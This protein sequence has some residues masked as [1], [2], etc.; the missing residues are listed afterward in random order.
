M[1]AT[2]ARHTHGLEITALIFFAVGLLLLLALVTYSSADPSFSVSGAA[3]SVKNAI[4]VIGSYLSDALLKL[5]GLC[6]YL[7]PFFFFAYAA[8]F[9]LGGEAVHPHLKKVGGILLFISLASLLGIQGDTVRLFSEDIPSGGMLGKLFV[10]LLVNSVS[11]TGAYI[12]AVTSLVIS[13]IML[14]PFSLVAVIDGLRRAFYG[15]L[16]R[17]ALLNDI[18]KGRAEKARAARAQ[19]SQQKEPPKI[20]GDPSA[21]SAPLPRLALRERNRQDKKDKSAKPV[22]A[23]FGFME[24]S[25]GG[26]KLPG[27]DLLDPLP[28]RIKKVSEKEMIAQSELLARKL[29][30]FDIQGRVSQVHPGPV[31]TMFEYEPAPGVKVRRIEG[32]ADDLALAMKAASV[33]IV[34]PLPGKAAVGIEV[35][36]NSRETVYF[37]EII[38]SP[39]YQGHR[40]KLRIPLGKDIFGMP[41]IAYVEKMP[42][43]LVA[44]ATGSGKSVAINSIILALLFNARPNEIRLV[45]VDPKMLELSLYN[46]IP[47]LL[48]PV[49]TQP[50]K[51]AETLRAVVAEMERRYR[52]LA[53]KGSKNIDSYNKSV[54]EKERLPYIVVIIDELADLMMTVQKEIEDSIMRLAQMARAAGIHL[55]V[56]TQRPS[57]DVVT[58]LIK[59]NLPSRIA[60]QVSSKTDSRTILDANGAESLLGKGDMLFL[61]PGSPH[62]VRIHGC[63]VSEEEIKRVVEFV[64]KQGKPNY[65]LLQQRVKEIAEAQTASVEEG[66]RDEEYER[67]VDLVQMNGQA[68]TSFLQRRLR[69]GYNRAARM[70]EMME[71]DGIVGPPDGS[72]PRKVLVRKNMDGTVHGLDA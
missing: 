47:H 54:M 65:E 53:E 36:N 39:E 29:L 51:A 5:F 2:K 59:A 9:A 63:F 61:P 69:V 6:A 20:A 68:S 13:L 42:H 28:P 19:P 64:K 25:V 62:L 37:R 41:T 45:M 8:Y 49:V 16:D 12:I 57:V 38:E 18:R 31:V 46:D 17:L 26:Y 10:V 56:A 27:A 50:K 72:K 1:S 7:I 15:A 21:P 60:F 35:P 40:S 52:Q 66:E 67:A 44:G 71:K 14:T 58:G 55:I 48:T 3:G 33:R 11:V 34:S 23:A 22:Q 32:L 43:L 30:D 4:G 24:E 70:I